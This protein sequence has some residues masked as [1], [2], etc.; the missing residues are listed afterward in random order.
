MV[1]NF[2]FRFSLS[3]HFE[4][5]IPI[6]VF[7]FCFRITLKNG[8]ELRFSFSHYFE[9]RIWISFLV[10]T[11]LWKTEFRLSLLHDLKNGS[12]HQSSHLKPRPLPRGWPNDM[13]IA[14]KKEAAI[15]TLTYPPWRRKMTNIS[16]LYNLKSQNAR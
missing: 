11:S 15:A 9:K 13:M 6:L 8:Y 5:R 10:F 14:A 12:L 3:H 16:T 7:V 4:K 2:V 1:L